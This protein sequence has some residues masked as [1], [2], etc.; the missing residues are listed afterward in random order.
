MMFPS[1][2]LKSTH[3]ILEYW[4][5]GISTSRSY[6]IRKLVGAFCPAISFFQYSS[7]PLLLFA[8]QTAFFVTRV[9]V[10]SPRGSKFTQLVPHHVFS[11]KHRDELL[12]IMHRYGQ[13]HKFRNNGGATGP[14]LDH[15]VISALLSTDYFSHQ[16]SINKRAF[17]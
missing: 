14:G 6:L 9:P 7:I 2:Y 3:G 1:P 13:T 8:S 11:N 12:A 4:N 10:K 15:S 16:T 5:D 17:L